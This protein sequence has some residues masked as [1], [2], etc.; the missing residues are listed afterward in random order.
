MDVETVNAHI[1][2]MRIDA[3]EAMGWATV[4]SALPLTVHDVGT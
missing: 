4:A 1:L 3:T 2:D